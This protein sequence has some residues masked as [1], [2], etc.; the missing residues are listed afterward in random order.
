MVVPPHAVVRP[1]IVPGTAGVPYTCNVRAAL[2]PAQFTDETPIV[3]EENP[4]LKLT[5]MLVVP[6]PLTIVP[7]AGTVHT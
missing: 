1:V 5:E 7:P 4:A 2:V 6:C 3:P